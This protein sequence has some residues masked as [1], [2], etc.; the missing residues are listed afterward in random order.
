MHGRASVASHRSFKISHAALVALKAD[1]AMSFAGKSGLRSN[2]T[3]FL[4]GK[5]E[6]E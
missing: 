4:E 6:E 1:V 3:I 2:V 5:V